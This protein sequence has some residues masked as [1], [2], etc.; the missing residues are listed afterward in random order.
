[1]L[2][3][4]ILLTTENYQGRI[5]KHQIWLKKKKKEETYLNTHTHT[6]KHTILWTKNY[7]FEVFWL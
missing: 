2:V 1:M 6:H 7:I 3:K 4:L 5:D